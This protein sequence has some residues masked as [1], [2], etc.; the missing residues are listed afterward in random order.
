M[1]ARLVIGAGIVSAAGF[2]GHQL[3]GNRPE[4]MPGRISGQSYRHRLGARQVWGD[5]LQMFAGKIPRSQT[6]WSPAWP[7]QSH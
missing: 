4:P 2:V 3:P 1:Q 6:T 5:S 7:D